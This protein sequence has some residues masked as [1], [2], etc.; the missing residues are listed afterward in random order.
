VT[1]ERLAMVRAQGDRTLAAA[2]DARGVVAV[3]EQVR[4][5]RWWWRER[6]R[7]GEGRDT[8]RGGGEG[9]RRE[10]R[11]GDRGS[12]TNGRRDGEGRRR[13]THTVRD[14]EREATGEARRTVGETVKA[15][16]DTGRQQW[17]RH[18]A[19]CTSSDHR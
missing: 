4:G 6:E 16:G 17:Q 11:G 18:G 2:R 1:A 15:E 14:A 13:E 3:A 12:K 7:R 5:L 19:Q 8:G 9:R 10:T